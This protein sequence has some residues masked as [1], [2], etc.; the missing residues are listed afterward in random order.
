M[1]MGRKGKIL[2]KLGET[3]RNYR[4][5]ELAM[6]ILLMIAAGIAI[7][8]AFIMPGLPVA[9]K[10]LLSQVM[11]QAGMRRSRSLLVSLSRLKKRGFVSVGERDGQQVLTLTERGKKRVLEYEIDRMAIKKPRKWDGFWRLV[12]FDIP[13]RRKRGREALR[14]KLKQLGFYPIQKSCFVYPFECRKEIEFISELFE[15]SPYVYYIV[16]KEMEGTKE[17]L[18]FFNLVSS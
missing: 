7:P 14:T 11:E 12:L 13:E 16:V 3:S 2:G 8:A 9:L 5:G 4:K 15:V 17:L 18:R 6:E 10:P 1:E